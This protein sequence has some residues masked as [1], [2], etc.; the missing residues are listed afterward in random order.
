MRRSL[1]IMTLA[2]WPTFTPAA[3]PVVQ[4]PATPPTVETWHLREVWRLDNDEDAALPLMGVITQAVV[5]P[6][7]NVLL[8]DSQLGH[9]LE[10]S[11]AG[12]F[13]GTLSRMGQGPGELERPNTIFLTADNKLGLVQVFPGKIV[14]VN[15][16]DTPAGSIVAQGVNSMFLRVKAV[17]GNLVVRGQT[18]AK[19]NA[20]ESSTTRRFLARYSPTGER[21]HVYLEDQTI[22]SYYPTHLTE[23]GKWFP[24]NSWTLA[25]D[26]SLLVAAERDEYRIQ[27]LELDG[28][29]R[30]IITRTFQPHVRTKAERKLTK[31]RMRTWGPGGELKV[32]KS[33]LDTEPAIDQI[34]VLPDG[35]IWVR[36]CYAERDLPPGIHCRYDV[37]D[38]QGHLES[39]V[40]IV[41]P[42][43]R[44]NDYFSL[45]ED[46]RFLWFRN[47]RSALNS[48]YA[49]IENRPPVSEDLADAED[50]VLQ[51]IMLERDN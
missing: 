40:R 35:R 30:R 42:V 4:N 13:L 50:L 5:A 26:G 16:D 2:L 7:G 1:A 28:S 34:Q 12:E 6:D 9:V 3:P 41:W 38:P 15:R 31:D 19:S 37:Y 14:L 44:E 32:R 24:Y 18:V 10:I 25:T 46:G 27:W 8:L 29:V 22:A 39:E 33:I 21:L 47:A 20:E 17:A 51:V 23:K 49:K 48:V 43:N 45:L 36:S 11:P